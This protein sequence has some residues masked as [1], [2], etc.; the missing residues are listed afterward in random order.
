V[1][2]LLW[3]PPYTVTTP[4]MLWVSSPIGGAHGQLGA[5]RPDRDAAILRD[6]TLTGRVCSSGH[7]LAAQANASNWLE[8]GT[9][10]EPAGLLLDS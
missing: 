4:L 5:R 10:L 1:A 7:G 8:L 2:S 9:K 3:Q 6:A